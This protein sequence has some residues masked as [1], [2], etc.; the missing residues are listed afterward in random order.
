MRALFFVLLGCLIL[1]VSDWLLEFTVTEG[2]D[3]YQLM[4]AGQRLVEGELSWTVEYFDKLLITQLL[5]FLPA[6][7]GTIQVWFIISV[8]FVIFGSYACFILV[9]DVLLSN[10]N[11]SLENRKNSSIIAAIS[12]LYLFSFLGPLQNLNAVSASSAAI[13]LALLLKSSF[14]YEN[15]KIY[16]FS[17][18]LSALFASI[19]IGVR[20]FFLFALIFS[21]ILLLFPLLKKFFG[22]NRALFISLLWIILIAIFGL[23]TNMVPYIIIGRTDVFF[24]GMSLLSQVPPP[25]G[26]IKILY[27]I[28]IDISK[29]HALA[30]F[31]IVLS[32]TSSIYATIIFVRSRQNIFT[33]DRMIYSIII[34]TVLMPILLLLM[35]LTRHYWSHYLQMFAPFWG[36]GLG[37]FFAVTISSLSSKTLK[38]SIFIWA[39]ALSFVMIAII[40]N[41]THN[42]REI[43]KNISNNKLRLNVGDIRLEELSKALLSFPEEKRDFIFLDDTRPHFLLKEPRH[44]FPLAAN[45]R[46]IVKFGWWK[47]ANMPDHFNHPKNSEEYCLALEQYGPTLIFI[48]DKLLDFE[49]TCLKKTLSY[50]FNQNLS[51]DVNLYLRN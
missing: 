40:P 21:A 41:L 4:Y 3:I 28:I 1:L 24:A 34:F 9:N 6:F 32:F 11:I 36:I 22:I 31:I 30:I 37:F 43:H 27:N 13:S 33:L 18:F 20:P 29:S 49:K 35:I 51:T 15:K 48:G 45:T 5:F 17:F 7:F 16:L 26:I 10:S 23:L 46:H 47:D 39:V 2:W 14:K 19:C 42:L 38:D 50:S 25:S 12:T 8:F 44:G